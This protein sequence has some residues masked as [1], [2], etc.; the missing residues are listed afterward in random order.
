ML[1]AIKSILG[2]PSSAEISPRDAH[3]KVR[4]GEV[5]LIDVREKGEWSA[6]RIP[7]AKHIPLSSLRDRTGKL[8]KDKE[9]V[10][11]CRSGARSAFAA[12]MLS[13]EG[14][15]A[16][17]L[18]GGVGAWAREGLPFKGRVS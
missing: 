4:A 2:G 8:P 10:L 16:V 5:V 11:V 18:E 6:G 1:R 12:K 14:Y 15:E 17:S 9:V 3:E 13:E 7:A